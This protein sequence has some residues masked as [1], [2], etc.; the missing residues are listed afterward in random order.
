LNTVIQTNGA[1]LTQSQT[2]RLMLAR[3]IADRPRLLLIDGTLDSLP[4][5]ALQSVLDKLTEPH[6]GWTLL[7]ATGR[8]AIAEACDR[9]VGMGRRRNDSA[10]LAKLNFND[11][12]DSSERN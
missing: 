6:T 3:A 11:G 12:D 2:V 9:T 10:A 5:E 8:R 7:V 1:P 4:D